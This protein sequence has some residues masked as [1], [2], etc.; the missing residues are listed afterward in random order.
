MGKIKT[1]PLVVRVKDN[2]PIIAVVGWA[3]FIIA[4]LV[5]SSVPAAKKVPTIPVL[6]QAALETKEDRT[7][8]EF[9]ADLPLEKNEA[10]FELTQSAGN[11]NYLDKTSTYLVAFKTPWGKDV[12]VEK[13]EKYLTAEGFK[14][15]R[16]NSGDNTVYLTG[17]KEDSVVSVSITEEKLVGAPEGAPTSYVHGAISYVKR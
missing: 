17:A 6:T 16:Q 7:P 9:P 15:N 3:A 12:A 11:L 13:Y 1:S 4:L 5:N 10:G 14:V 2:L 8:S